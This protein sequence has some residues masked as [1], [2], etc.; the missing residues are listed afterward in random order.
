MVYKKILLC[1]GLTIIITIGTTFIRYHFIK[2]DFWISFCAYFGLVFILIDKFPENKKAILL[3][4]LLTIIGLAILGWVIDGQPPSLGL[5]NIIGTL[6]ACISG[7][8][9]YIYKGI[10]HRLLIISLCVFLCVFYVFYG[11][12]YWLNYLNYGTATGRMAKKTEVNWVYDINDSSGILK[13]I[14]QNDNLIVLDFFNTACPVCFAKFPILQKIYN[15]YKD[16]SKITIYAIN[17][18]LKRDTIGM[19]VDMVKRKNFTFPV[20]VG[21][22]KLDSVFD[23]KSYPTTILLKN[24]TIIFK[25]DIEDAYKKV[26]ELINK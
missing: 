9:F 15:Q 16:N 22:Y 13:K 3:S 11:H 17:I 26:E 2:Y 5:T 6:I 24:N 21:K 12:K 14:A 19:A 18:P 23:I 10:R 4:F 8:M 20:M 1:I 7:F 25:G